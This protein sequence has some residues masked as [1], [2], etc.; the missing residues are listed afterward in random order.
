MRIILAPDK[1]KGSLTTFEVANAMEEGLQEA[2]AQFTLVK[3]PMADGGDGLVE[4]IRHYPNASTQTTP[5]QDPLGRRIEAEWLL[6]ADG[7]TAI[8]EMAKASGLVRLRQDEYNPLLTS[9]Y[10][11]G[12]LIKAALEKGAA[13]IILG[14]GGSATN[15]GGIG[16]AAAIGYRFFD[17]EGAELSPSGGNLEKIKIIESREKI[18]LQGVEIVV[19]IDVKNPLLGREGASFIYGPQKGA[20]PAMVHV[21]ERGMVHFCAVVKRDLGIDL[22]TLEG[23]G[24]A[25]GLGAGSVAFLGATVGSGIHLVMQY[26]G[27]EEHIANADVVL[28][29]EGKLDT[30]TL[31][32]KLVTG[33]AMLAKKYGKKVI[34]LCGNQAIPGPVAAASGIDAVFAVTKYPMDLPEAKE[35][36]YAFVKDTA[37]S[38]GRLL[39]IQ[40]M[41]KG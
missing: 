13:K 4:V 34:A 18:N 23:G 9:T 1:F 37:F 24:A 3:C 7:K 11:T 35:K 33:V 21:L 19:A 20:D 25:G 30:Q 41:A 38:V 5:V 26:A 14:I 10:G 39:H 8:I 2:S 32:G 36:A 28:T 22:T 6:A 31:N 12:Q 29:G 15:D 17:S 27:L 40:A 16:M